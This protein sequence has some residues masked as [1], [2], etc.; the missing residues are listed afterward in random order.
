MEKHCLAELVPRRVPWMTEWQ[1]LVA[2]IVYVW[3][4]AEQPAH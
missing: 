2:V 3:Y 1:R 4:A